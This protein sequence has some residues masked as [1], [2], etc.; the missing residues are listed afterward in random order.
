MKKT[1]LKHRTRKF[2]SF[3]L[4]VC[5]LTGMLSL[6]VSAEAGDDK[7]PSEDCF[8]YTYKFLSTSTIAIT[9]YNGY[10]TE[11][12]VPSKI[13]GYTVTSV[14]GFDTTKTKK[15]TL[16]E[17]V[18]TI[19][20]S[21]FATYDNFSYSVLEE[22]TLPRNLKYIGAGAFE[23]CYFLTSIDIPESVTKIGNGAFYGCDNLKNI[24]VKSDI[25]IGNKAFGDRYNLIPAISKTYEDS[26]SDFFV[27]NGWVFEYN[28]NSQNPAIPSGTVGIYDDVF[29]YSGITSVTIPE[30]VK[31]INYGAFQQCT[32]LKNIKLPNSLVRIN[33]SA[34]KECTSLSTLSLGEGLKT[35]DSEVFKGCVGLKTVA[36]PSK[37]ETLEYEAFEDCSN[38]EN[39]TFP[40]TLTTADESAFYETKWY[41]NIK[42]GTALYYGSVFNGFKG[43][44]TCLYTGSTFTVKDGTKT[45]DLSGDIGKITKFV[46]PNTLKSFTMSRVYN[47]SGYKLTSLALPESVDYV[48]ITNQTDLKN[49]TLPTTAKLG[50]NCFE[51]CSALETLTVPKGNT[52]LEISLS[53]CSSL[54]KVVLADD[55]VELGNCALGYSDSLTTVDLKNVRI[56]SSEA[57]WHCPSIQKITIPDTVTTICNMAFADCSNLTTVTGGKNVKILE[58]AA[59]KNCTKLTS[60]GN[61]GQNLKNLGCIVFENTKWFENQKDGIVY[62]GKIAYCYKGNMPKNTT[63]TFKNGTYAVSSEFIS[64]HNSATHFEQPNLVKV[65]L[66]KSCKFIG[67]DAFLNCTN[68]KSIDLGGA[69]IAENEAFVSNACETITLPST[70]RIIGDDSFTSKVL[71]TVNLNDGLQ[72][73]GEGAFFSYGKIKNMTV[74]ASVTHIGVQ[75]IGYYPPDPDDPFVPSE[76]IPNFVIY[77]T[78]GTEA[79]TYADRNGIQFNSIASGTTVKGTA[80]SYLSADDTVT[81][82]LEKSGVAVYETTVKGN[83]TDY[84]ISGVANGTYTMRVSKKL[85]ADREYTVKVSSANVTQNVEIFPIGDVNSDGDISVVD[86]TLVQKYIVGLEK[87]TDLQKKSAEV[88]GDGEISVVDA[89]LIQK[90]IVG[91]ENFS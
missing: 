1:K 61:I 80:K 7:L 71:K 65:V 6:S 69:E 4:A 76:V 88:N 19:G 30:G 66:P 43:Y 68:L 67:S 59:F 55:T 62:L 41:N 40:N 29:A 13:D 87:L 12:T 52:R 45:V 81:I 18:T 70:M 72:A 31:Y 26:Q 3:A 49:L 35:I 60:I 36:L 75:A 89:T 23:N 46:F 2:I 77:G 73:I 14:E 85:H 51:Y 22:V 17:T 28:G 91:L 74:P 10:D 37:L 33:A 15:I 83:S 44:N 42:D 38:L 64:E 57:F 47:D 48:M 63:L 56:I 58:N 24:S 53:G 11:V 50:Y 9:D 8:G 27:W 78:S 21:A 86:A 39:V 82:Q 84:S 90:Y 20:D 25:D 79:Q 16:P 32:T 5:L 34:F 54:K